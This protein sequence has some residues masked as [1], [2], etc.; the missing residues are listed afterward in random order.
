MIEPTFRSIPFDG[1]HMQRTLIVFVALLG[2]ATAQAQSVKK[3]VIETG[4]AKDGK[5][6]LM[7]RD[8]WQQL[9]V[10]G[11]DE[12]NQATD[13]TRDVKYEASPL[14]IVE[15]DET[16]LVTP[17]KEGMATISVKEGTASA[18]LSVEV[19]RL[20]A[21]VPINFANQIVP[22]FTKFG[23]NAG[24]CHGKSG[25]QNHFS[26]SLLGF[27]PGEDYEYLVKETRGRRLFPAA[28]DQSLLLTK[29]AGVSAHGGG[30]RF[31]VD[32]P[33]YRLIRRW[34]QQGMP[35]G[36]PSDPDVVR[37]EVIPSQRVLP[38]E[39]TQ[40]LAVVAHF[41]DG[42]TADVT[43]MT[44]FETNDA[45]IASVSPTGLVTIKKRAGSVGVMTR[46]QIH[47]DV[48]RALVPLGASVGALPKAR[49][50]IDELIAK[51]WQELGLPPSGPADDAT[52]LRRV[53]LDIAGRLP[54]LEESKAFL[55]DKNTDRQDRLVDR[56][57]DSPDYAYYFANKWSAVLRN[58]R[59]SDKE[60]PKPTMNFHAWIKDSLH[61]NKPFDQF[62]REIVTAT[63]TAEKIPQALWYRE[64]SKI[65]DQVEDLSQLFLGQRIGCA[66]CHHHPF[67]KWSQDDYY[68]MAAFFARVETKDPPAPKKQKTDKTNPPK[69]PFEVLVKA[70]ADASAVNPKTNQKRRPTG[71]GGKEYPIAPDEDPRGKLVDWM[72]DPSNPFF[73]RALVNRYW[74]HFMGRGLVEPE[75]DLR[76]T[77]PATHPELLDALAK[78]FVDSK[79]DLKKLVRLITTSNVYR[80]SADPN[81][82]N[83]ADRQNY[84]RFLA[85]RLPA[86]V[87]LDSIDDLTG[88]RTSFKGMPAG[89]RAVQLPDNQFDSYFLSVFGR[90]DSASA[91]EC[92]RSG[93]SNLAQSLHLLNS[94]DVQNKI[95]KGRLQT[96]VKEKRD[97]QAK[98]RDLYLLAYS[99]APSDEEMSVAMKHLEARAAS[100]QVAYEDLVWAI[101]NTKEFL[102]NH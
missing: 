44:Q 95:S 63:G 86:E 62:V 1:L 50:I 4:R 69:P 59:K 32:S 91:C 28:P 82:Y 17:L 58:R 45:E 80:L 101:I 93:D 48:F 9:V 77:N 6:Q 30:K 41:S 100:P 2:I 79:Y 75:D 40:Q 35:T 18:S 36:G 38:R 92:E 56:L 27:E 81:E 19:G 39:G 5:V 21:D 87:L 78:A 49:N 46:F 34:I 8:A 74:K 31:E 96:L 12:K 57:L 102:F 13:R 42:T 68:G 20:E 15:I 11:Y 61:S 67:E 64:V 72:A 73:A 65:N 76:V 22:I 53:T 7:G 14:G 33:Y 26:L 98:I 3:L 66:R 29:A 97:H 25:G 83:A 23:C 54:T 89:T 94:P 71:L 43:R 51:R 47:V 84:S 37:I 60:D 70:K 55:E 85:R 24:G 52:F 99:R 88:L 16:G 10:T 90:P